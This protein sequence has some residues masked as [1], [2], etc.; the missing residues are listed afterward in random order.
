MTPL[1]QKISTD[2]IFN[3]N[4]ILSSGYQYFRAVSNLFTNEP[5]LLGGVNRLCKSPL[6]TQSTRAL[7]TDSRDRQTYEPDRQTDRQ[8]EMR[9]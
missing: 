1:K 9:S 2:T 7:Q 5:D 3:K 6:F 4:V 8:T